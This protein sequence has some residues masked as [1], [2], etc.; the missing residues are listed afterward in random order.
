MSSV[1]KL[2]G[3]KSSRAQKILILNKKGGAGKS[4][5]AI[6]LSSVLSR[7]CRTEL[8][9]L[10]EQRTSHYWSHNNHRVE[11]HHFNFDRGQLFSLAVKV[12]R[13]CE[14]IVIDT[15][16]NFSAVELERY[17]ALAD[18]I[19]IPVQP[20]P[21]DI[22][23]MLNFTQQLINTATSKHRRIPVAIVATRNEKGPQGVELLKRVLGHLRYPL[24]GSMSNSPIYPQAFEEGCNFM[25]I[26]PSLDAQ[27]WSKTCKWL[28]L[29][30]Y[31]LPQGE[32]LKGPSILPDTFK[33]ALERP[34]RI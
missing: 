18:R 1:R 34:N 25:D 13:E 15:P 6:S 29:P 19:V 27:L 3:L 22:H 17:I 9:D 30:R 20:T 8:L 32:R 26:N 23:A 21:V 4:T 12:D 16:S 11:G 10:D 2:C 28:K 7:H 33:L 14:V 5:L 24:L 31:P